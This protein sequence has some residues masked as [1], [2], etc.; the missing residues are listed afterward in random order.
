MNVVVLMK[1]TKKTKGPLI[2]AFATR[3]EAHRITGGYGTAKD[4]A[5]KIGVKSG[6][7]G[8]WERAE[9]EPGIEMIILICTT[10]GI[11]PNE[12]LW[13]GQVRSTESHPKGRVVSLPPAG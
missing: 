5:D 13:G 1:K 9:T 8:R 11:T 10:L 7:Y 12:L 6:A 3:L 4:F 2:Q